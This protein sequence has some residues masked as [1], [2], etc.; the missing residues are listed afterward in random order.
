MNQAGPSGAVPFRMPRSSSSASP[1]ASDSHLRAASPTS[2]RALMHSAADAYGQ[3]GGGVP[4]RM[5]RSSFSALTCAPGLCGLSLK[6][7]ASQSEAAPWRTHAKRR[8]AL[9]DVAQVLQR[10]QLAPASCASSSNLPCLLN[11]SDA[12]K[13]QAALSSKA[14]CA[15][16][17]AQRSCPPLKALL[18]RQGPCKKLATQQLP[19]APSPQPQVSGGR[20]EDYMAQHQQPLQTRTAAR[21]QSESQGIAG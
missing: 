13:G 14:R 18:A 17:L 21:S 12:C 9:G 7:A 3:T 5:P 4:L 1:S 15:P 16:D 11:R 20:P 8:G 19:A 2:A 6:L 10:L